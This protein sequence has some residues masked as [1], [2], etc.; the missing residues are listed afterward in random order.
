MYK[1][2]TTQFGEMDCGRS[3]EES[4]QR[5]DVEDA[6]TDDEVYEKCGDVG[7]GNS[8]VG[9]YIARSRKRLCD[10]THSFQGI[11]K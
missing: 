8:E 11:H 6:E 3:C 2:L 5:K 10:V 4:D 1:K 9:R 7:G